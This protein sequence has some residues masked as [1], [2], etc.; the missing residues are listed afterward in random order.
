MKRREFIKK[1]VSTVFG[2]ALL[3]TF[4]PGSSFAKSNTSS[5]D[6]I[7]IAS[8]GMGAMGMMNLGA[9]L[10]SDDCHVIAVCDIDKNHLLEAKEAVDKHYDNQDCQGYHDFREV[11]S[12][13][14]IDAVCLSMP[15]HW[16]SIPAVEAARAGKDIYGEKPLS[17]TFW[18]GQKIREAVNRYSRIWQT[19]SWQRSSSEFRF[20]C[21]LVMNG[22]IGDV[23]TVEVGLL[24]GPYN[25]DDRME[26]FGPPPAALDYDRWL[27]P[28]P[29]APY[30]PARVHNAWRWNLDYG[31]GQLMDWI[32]HHVDIAH[33]ALDL[34]HTG[35]IEIE[36]KGEFI[37]GRIWNSAQRYK[38][39]SIYANGVQMTIAGGYSEIKEGVKFIGEDGWI[40]VDRGKLDASNRKL[41][42][43]TLRPDE[44]HLYRSPGHQQNFLDCVRSR[45][46]T[47]TPS[48]IAHRSATPGHLGQIS[49]LLGRKL[50]FDPETET[51]NNDPMAT[52]MLSKSMRDPWYL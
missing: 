43:H 21:E 42:S 47:L 40:W 26:V 33:W 49:M 39:H 31:G 4:L 9:F 11:L 35:P 50:Y 52:R 16:H 6:K 22:Y 38:V 10:Y 3:P 17:H 41:L 5:N 7:N 1:T 27:G 12:R 19:G 14:D 48:E 18:E 23:K 8:I 32:G 46:K 20:A 45:Q 29:Y 28:A 51:I 34:D 13:E 30:C 2:S 36:G 15:D 37:K 24:D 25:F 44:R